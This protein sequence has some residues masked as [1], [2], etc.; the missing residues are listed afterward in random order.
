MKNIYHH[1]YVILLLAFFMLY[2]QLLNGQ[3]RYLD[4]K[5]TIVFEAS[6]E[7]FEEVKAKSESVTAILDPAKNEIA[8]LALIRGF[9]F[10]NS[11][12]QEHFNENYIESDLYPK[13][14]FRGEILDFDIN[15]LG[16]TGKEYTIKGVLE[17]R[18]R[19]KT[20]EPIVQ[21]QKI[22]NVI[23]LQ[24]R[25][26]VRPKDFDIQIPKIVEN[27]IAKVVNVRF[28]FKLAANENE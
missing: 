4:K 8:S 5:G 11:L 2:G 7:F 19:K 18:E 20:I 9:R 24:G 1:C 3:K 23:S 17:I 27:K 13:A 12:M 16:S 28:D 6:E 25:F 10:K 22:D 15:E 26:E 21:I 14:I